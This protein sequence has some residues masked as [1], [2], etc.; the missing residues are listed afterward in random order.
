MITEKAGTKQKKKKSWKR[1]QPKWKED[2]AK[3][4]KKKSDLSLLIEI[5]NG[6]L[7]NQRKN[8]QIKKRYTIKRKED[9]AGAKE[10]IKQQIQAKAQRK[11]DTRKEPNSLDRTSSSQ[12]MLRSFTGNLG[13]ARFK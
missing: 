3:D 10:K 11:G 13:K 12:Q 1:K 5:E 4:I 2:I 9:I 7:V 6:T 8:R